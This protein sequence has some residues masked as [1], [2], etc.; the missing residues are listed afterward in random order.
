MEQLSWPYPP[1]PGFLLEINIYESCGIA[2]I[3]VYFE[4][5]MEMKESFLG[6]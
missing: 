6:E 3:T 1:P 5:S 2:F 4:G